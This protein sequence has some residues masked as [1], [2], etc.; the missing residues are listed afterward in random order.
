MYVLSH[1]FLFPEGCFLV[2]HRPAATLLF[3]ILWRTEK[4]SVCNQHKV[5]REISLVSAMLTSIWRIKKKGWWEKKNFGWNSHWWEWG[6][7]VGEMANGGKSTTSVLK[8]YQLCRGIQLLSAHSH[9]QMGIWKFC[10]CPS[11]KRVSQMPGILHLTGDWQLLRNTKICC[12][13]VG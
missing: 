2:C 4:H 1:H 3:N 6:Q 8:P 10:K 7:T 12:S 5:S 9:R 11:G 13:C